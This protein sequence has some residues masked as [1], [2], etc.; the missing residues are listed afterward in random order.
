MLYNAESL[1]CGR[2]TL[3]VYRKKRGCYRSKKHNNSLPNIQIIVCKMPAAEPA[4]WIPTATYSSIN[5]KKKV[6]TETDLIAELNGWK[7][8]IRIL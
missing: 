2:S 8:E 1:F 3:P 5:A 4:F 7:S 6:Q